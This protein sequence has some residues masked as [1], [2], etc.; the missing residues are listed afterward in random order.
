MNRLM[1]RLK[2][3][4]KRRYFWVRDERKIKAAILTTPMADGI[5]GAIC[6]N[7]GRGTAENSHNNKNGFSF[8]TRFVIGMEF[9]ADEKMLFTTNNVSVLQKEDKWKR[10]ISRQT[11][12]RRLLSE[13]IRSEIDKLIAVVE[14]EFP[15]LLG[16]LRRPKNQDEKDTLV[17]LVENVGIMVRGKTIEQTLKEADRNDV[18]SLAVVFYYSS[19]PAA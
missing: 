19:L 12:N 16:S 8:N 5:I 7:A 4:T 15:Q 9:D 11:M 13:G 18:G 2:V 10:G 3:V 6:T 1:Q 14:L 17:Q